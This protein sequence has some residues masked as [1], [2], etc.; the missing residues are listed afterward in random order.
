M[1][2]ASLFFFLFFKS[3]KSFNVPFRLANCHSEGSETTAAADIKN[4]KSFFM[5]LA[6]EKRNLTQ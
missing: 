4:S 6:A 1:A 5:K 3:V 2:L